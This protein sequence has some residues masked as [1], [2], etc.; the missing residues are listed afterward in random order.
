MHGETWKLCDIVYSKRQVVLFIVRIRR[1]RCKEL[2]EFEYRFAFHSGISFV[3]LKLVGSVKTASLALKIFTWESF[4]NSLV[5]TWEVDI[6]AGRQIFFIEK[7]ENTVR[8]K[9]PPAKTVQRRPTNLRTNRFV[10]ATTFKIQFPFLQWKKS[11]PSPLF[12]EYYFSSPLWVS[13]VATSTS[14]YLLLYWD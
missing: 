13:T 2:S 6:I 11:Q 9:C 7:T 14:F 5:S 8:W 4:S 12:M 3:N 10:Q 1:L